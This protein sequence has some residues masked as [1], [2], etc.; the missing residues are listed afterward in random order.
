VIDDVTTSRDCPKYLATTAADRTSPLSPGTA[1]FLR[2][3]DTIVIGV[4]DVKKNRSPAAI[5][6][7]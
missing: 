6:S 7:Y 3:D 5:C 1:A 2:S 4:R